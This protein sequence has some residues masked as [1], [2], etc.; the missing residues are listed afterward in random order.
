MPSLYEITIPVFIRQLNI[1][2]KLLEHGV[3]FA[4]D[5]ANAHTEQ[6]LVD[7]RLIADMQTL[8]YQ[9]ASSPS[10][11]SLSS[12]PFNFLPTPLHRLG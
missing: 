6:S 9:S 4:N 12:S 7:A 11:P 1:L 2:A 3:A 10:H 5:S 8:A